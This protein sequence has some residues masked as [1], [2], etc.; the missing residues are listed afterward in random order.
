MRPASL[1]ERQAHLHLRRYRLRPVN[2]NKVAFF[3]VAA[4]VISLTSPIHAQEI[5]PAITDAAPYALSA[6]SFLGDAGNTDRIRG[7]RIQADG[8]LVLAANLTSAPAGVTPLLLNGATASS[9]GAILRMTPD[10]KTI[11]SLTRVGAQIEDLAIDDTGNL[12]AALWADG[13]VKLDPTATQVLWSRRPASGKV[14]RIDAGG[15]G[16]AV[17][18]V[19]SAN[20]PEAD[21]PGAGTVETYAPDGSQISSV[22]GKSNTLDVCLHPPSQT[23]VLIGWR[24]ANVSGAP[25]QIA[26]LQGRGYDGA[27]KYTTYDWSTDA[28]SDRFINRPE[29]NMADTRGYRCAIGGDGKLYAAFEAA[30]GNHIFRYSPFDIAARVSI[31]GGDQWHAFFNTRAEHKTFFAR[32]DAATGAYL[33]GQQLLTRLSSGAG[34]TLRVRRGAIDADALGRVYIGGESAWGLPMPPHP[35]YTPKPGETTF[36]H[37][38]ANA[39]AYLGGAWFVVMSADLKTRLYVTRLTT[40]GNT[41]ALDARVIAGDLANIA[42]AG[43]TTNLTETYALNAVQPA[44]S[45]AQ[46]GWFGV[47]APAASAVTACFSMTPSFGPPPLTVAFDASASTTLTGTITN[48]AWAFGDGALGSGVQVT[49]T[50]ASAG[51]FTVVMTVTNNVG[52]SASATQTLV[53]GGQRVLMPVIVR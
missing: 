35:A 37:L 49:H 14:M 17:A 40:G 43:R 51:V 53:V 3:L 12:Y 25:V 47:I 16:H 10:G 42:F 15:A 7:A 29:N 44:G 28:A 13:V 33:A 41:D 8:T 46:E 52:Q 20:D 32:Y 5:T 36:N 30:G 48:Y 22:V 6:A 21:A 38:A 34:N 31:T 23:A 45:G 9:A 39:G 18:L 2:V 4:L 1:G 11:L 50:Y 24:Q 26:Y 19:T 27:A